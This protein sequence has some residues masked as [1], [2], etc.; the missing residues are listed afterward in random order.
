VCFA[1]ARTLADM[2]NTASSIEY[3]RKSAAIREAIT[4]GSPAFQAF[5]QTRL[6][7]VYG[8]MSGVVHMQ[9]DTDSA[10]ALQSKS[11]DILARQV[12]ADPQ[13]AT[14]RQFLLQA[15]YWVGYYLEEKGLPAQ[16]LPHF[17]TALAGYQALTS[18]D[19][20]NALAMRYLSR[21]Y[22]SVG[23]ALAAE[24]KAALGIQPARQALQIIETLAATDRTDTFYKSADLAYA[25]SALAEVCS[26]LAE[27]SSGSGASKIKNWREAR[28][29]YQ[30]SLDTWLLLQQKAPLGKFDAAQPDKIAIEIAKCDAALAKLNARNP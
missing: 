1:M 19:A 20:H 4:G 10:L 17:Q 30:K 25:R 26:R 7:G 3:Y 14:L 21:C 8:Y 27:Q 28:A 13:N 6:A 16:A 22:W 29:W 23:K 2:G 18:I 9:G 11:R 12:K 5:V 24:G 15:E